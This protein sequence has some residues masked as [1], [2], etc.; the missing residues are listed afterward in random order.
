MT[1]IH[2]AK[3]ITSGKFEQPAGLVWES[4][5]TITGMLPGAQC[6][7]HTAFT[8]YKEGTQPTK[9][10]DGHG[11]S[12]DPSPDPNPDATTTEPNSNPNQSE[13]TTDPSQQPNPPEPDPEG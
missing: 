7:G 4:Y 3:G 9:I 8:F 13:T 12:V 5:C 2:Q 11:G 1:K 10:C 6:A